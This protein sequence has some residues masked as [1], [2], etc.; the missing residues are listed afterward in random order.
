[1][2]SALAHFRLTNLLIW[3]TISCCW[4]MCALSTPRTA[5]HRL[6]LPRTAAICS[7]GNVRL[8]CSLGYQT[9]SYLSRSCHAASRWVIT[10]MMQLNP[11]VAPVP[12]AE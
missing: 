1:M 11:L 10:Y 2:G 5:S 3:L 8:R 6:A 9:L 12:M 7:L 4:L